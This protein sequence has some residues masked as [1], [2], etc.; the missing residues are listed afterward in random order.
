[1]NTYVIYAEQDGWIGL[2]PFECTAKTLADAKFQWHIECWK[3]GRRIY[4][5]ELVLPDYTA[6]VLEDQP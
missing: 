2:D 1:M 6:I 3:L 4:R 5:C